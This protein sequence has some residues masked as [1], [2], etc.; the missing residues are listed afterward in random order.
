[1]SSLEDTRLND[2]INN[3]FDNQSPLD[4]LNN[5]FNVDPQTSGLNAYQ[6]S[7]NLYPH[8]MDQQTGQGHQYNAFDNQLQQNSFEN[9]F[10]DGHH[11]VENAVEDSHQV[12]GDILFPNLEDFDLGD[13]DLDFPY[14]ADPKAFQ[15]NAD[16]P[17]GTFRPESND[18]LALGT[19]DEAQDA[20]GQS[21]QGNYPPQ[22]SFA[23]NTIYD[24]NQQFVETIQTGFEEPEFGHMLPNVAQPRSA[25]NAAPKGFYEE[26]EDNDFPP[27]GY[28]SGSEYRNDR[29]RPYE[30]SEEE[31][32]PGIFH[33]P[34]YNTAPRTRQVSQGRNRL[35]HPSTGRPNRLS[36]GSENP[37]PDGY[38]DPILFRLEPP[39][40]Y[41][42]TIL[43]AL[44]DRDGN[45]LVDEKGREYKDF[46]GLPW[47][48][49]VRL[50]D[51]TLELYTDRTD[52]RIQH[53]DLAI[54]MVLRPGEKVPHENALNMQRSRFRNKYNIACW[55]RKTKLPSLRDCLLMEVID[56]T[57]VEQNTTSIVTEQGIKAAMKEAGTLSLGIFL[58]RGQLHTPSKDLEKVFRQIDNLQSLAIRENI[59]HW[60]FLPNRLKPR[61]WLKKSVAAKRGRNDELLGPKRNGPDDIIFP[62]ETPAASLHW[63]KKCVIDAA[64][65][66]LPIP[67]LNSLPAHITGW[68]YDC[69]KEGQQ[70][71]EQKANLARNQ[72]RRN[73][74]RPPTDPSVPRRS[75]DSESV[76]RGPDSA[77]PPYH[78]SFVSSNATPPQNLEEPSALGYSDKGKGRL[79][80]IGGSTR[81]DDSAAQ[82]TA[83]R[84]R[85]HMGSRRMVG[86]RPSSHYSQLDESSL[87]CNDDKDGDFGSVNPTQPGRT[88]LF[89][90][91][92][93]G[94]SQPQNSR[95]QSQVSGN[96]GRRDSKMGGSTK[97][98][99]VSSETSENEAKRL[100]FAQQQYDQFRANRPNR[101]SRN[102]KNPVIDYSPTAMTHPAPNLGSSDTIVDSSRAS[103]LTSSGGHDNQGFGSQPTA[104]AIDNRGNA[105]FDASNPTPRAYQPENQGFAQDEQLSFMPANNA[106]E[107]LDQDG[108]FEIDSE[109][110][111]EQR[112]L[113]LAVTPRQQFP[114]ASPLPPLPNDTPTVSTNMGAA[115]ETGPLS[116]NIHGDNSSN[117]LSDGEFNA[118]LAAAYDNLP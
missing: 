14:P 76:K 31:D 84:E 46:P 37:R 66:G 10:G 59:P 21:A 102:G 22:D 115:M 44:L 100:K 71:A 99:R 93:S 26:S 82:E 54:R 70:R 74:Q 91:W 106:Q 61:E 23:S 62:V 25:R 8:D 6:T 41:G 83:T 87:T 117:L 20:F 58:R 65:N 75:F 98:K 89:I 24:A 94:P 5:G 47:E 107:D 79:Y 56:R 90:N 11:Q 36:Y 49:P 15:D 3:L 40:R 52:P 53:R 67:Q 109:Y 32:S 55:T 60:I 77:N 113:G 108:E 112:A 96:T 7:G 33:Q 73:R 118:L 13:F 111:E 103:E 17:L 95:Q 78:G 101:P 28:N 4:S 85:H 116:D 35:S 72:D 39:P 42:E 1:M 110:E 34:E 69:I 114:T 88:E 50:D 2:E 57:S 27:N 92:Y 30:S 105:H 80:P 12:P 18:N 16:L 48:I 63:I 29:S 51:Q 81:H 9:T 97:R 68:M 104:N 45:P 64:E 19:V 43:R 38:I 86:R